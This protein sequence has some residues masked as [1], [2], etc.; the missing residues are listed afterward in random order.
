MF[1][2][3]SEVCFCKNM[4]LNLCITFLSVQLTTVRDVCYTMQATNDEESENSSENSFNEVVI[5]AM[6]RGYAIM[7]TMMVPPQVNPTYRHP[8]ATGR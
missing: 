5:A 6:A 4:F 2:Q 1:L 7:S 3:I 8:K